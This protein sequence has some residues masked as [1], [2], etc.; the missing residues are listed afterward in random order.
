M[1][2]K[3]NS[4]ERFWQELKRR[5]T[6]KVIIAYAAT[7]FILL[8]LAD[9]LTP[10]LLLPEWTTRLVTLIL[11]IGFPLSII[12][13]WIFDLTPQGIKKTKSSRV[14]E[15][16]GTV[17]IPARRILS[18]SNIIIAALIIVVAILAYPKIFKRDTLENLRA[19]G[20]ISIAVMPFKNRTSDPAW[21]DSQGITQDILKNKLSSSE[22]LLVR[23][24][25][26][27]DYLIQSQGITN[28]A[29]MTP[30][31][32]RS[33]SR[34]LGANIFISGSINQAGDKVRLLA[35][36]KDSKTG[37]IIKPFQIEGPSKEENILNIIDPL[38][39]QVRDFLVISK[40]EKEV[41]PDFQNLASFNSPEAYR[42][43]SS[44]NISFSNKDFP[45][46][47]NLL[48]QAIDIDSN[49]ISAILIVPFAYGNQG[50]YEG[51]K[52]WCLK[53][54]KKMNQMN[55]RQKVWTKRTYAKFFETPLEDIKYLRQ[56]LKFD[57][58]LPWL[59]FNMGNDYNELQQFD[60]AIIELEKSLEIYKKW[61]SK[62]MWIWN[63]T[64]LG[65][66]YHKLGEYKKENK[67]YKKAQQ[68]FPDDPDLLFRQAVLALSEGN[69]KDA[70]DIIEKYKSI[71]KDNSSS[72]KDI[73]AGIAGIYSEAGIFAIAEEYY[74]EAL[75]IEPENPGML[76][77]LA[78]FLIDKERNIDEGLKLIDKALKISP[79]N[80][81]YQ[82]TKGWGLYKQGKYREALD[83]LQKSWDLRREKAVYDHEA[84]LHL[85][86]AKKAISNQKSN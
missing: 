4:F 2:Q 14:S 69:A 83:I 86:S 24:T 15:I 44:G 66:S 72:E 49:F 58:Q 68:D 3:T 77:N 17:K 82:D 71:R 12:F 78:W 48:E 38:S 67:L 13:S 64:N 30:S 65:Y 60:N 56:L 32:E 41:S 53:A 7:A 47:V 61:D 81:L 21:K 19:K 74:R 62:P 16:K 23:E 37:K 40:L 6:G 42:Y 50:L 85:D 1:A 36:L 35:E 54:Y 34:K 9:I 75:S 5:K 79:D 11:I 18:V 29:S 43:F 51:A 70:I 8:Q 76:N 46:A 28:T 39:I 73:A 63:Y 57:D 10:A 33:I 31:L 84:F 59:Y 27:I 22:E 45:T 20:K 80:Y 25:E 52:K 26:S 55:M